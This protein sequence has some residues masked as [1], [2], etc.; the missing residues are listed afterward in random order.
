MSF[1]Q[2]DSSSVGRHP[3]AAAAAIAPDDARIERRSP[4]RPKFVVNWRK[5]IE[6]QAAEAERTRRP[7]ALN[8]IDIWLASPERL[9]RAHSCLRLLTRDDWASFD[10]I[11]DGSSRHNAMAARIL[12]R[13]GLSQSVDRRIAPGDWKFKTG[14]HGK[15][16]LADAL[17]N[18]RFS[19]SHTDQLAA[20]AIS[21]HLEVGVDV[22]SV[23]Q[24]VSEK[25]VAG[26]SHPRE[27]S[28]LRDLMPRQKVREFIRLWTFKEA[29][30]K[31]IGTGMSLD[32]DAVQF[33][34]DPAQLAS[35]GEPPASAAREE[36]NY[37]QTHFESI[38]VSV[39]HF[40][41]H[42]SLAVAKPNDDRWVPTEVRVITLSEPGAGVRSRVPSAPRSVAEAPHG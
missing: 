40:L 29:L 5:N 39:E 41:Y 4:N 30:A 16:I 36:T 33:T 37:R 42:V 23:D 26:F 25:V 32:F 10:R 9:L 2:C 11:K 28:E 22:E 18:I 12:L 14:A 35:T 20:V 8:Y 17:P 27:T 31:L 15:P 6:P 21:P 3:A 38:Y 13:L 7:R 1:L 24:N 34:L 19:A